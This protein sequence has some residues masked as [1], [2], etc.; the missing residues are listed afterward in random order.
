MR[1]S[2]LVLL[3]I[4]PAAACNRSNEPESLTATQ[5][6]APT[7]ELDSSAAKLS[8]TAAVQSLAQVKASIA[9]HRG[10][11]LVVDLWALW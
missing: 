6:T 5:A 4:L 2:C 3:S 7:G 11:V 1:F 9:N 8:V 10:K